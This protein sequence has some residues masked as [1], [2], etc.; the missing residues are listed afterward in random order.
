MNYLRD[1]HA[2]DPVRQRKDPWNMIHWVIEYT[3]RHRCFIIQ[4]KTQAWLART[5]RNK[6]R[7]R[8]PLPAS[9]QSMTGSAYSCMDA[10]KITSVY[11]AETYWRLHNIR[12]FLWL[13]QRLEAFTH[14]PQEIIN[15]R[16]FVH[17]IE[18]AATSQHDFNGVSCTLVSSTNSEIGCGK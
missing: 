1:K 14:L 10:V 2:T 15:E 16:S 3:T 13:P 8:M 18:C 9:S 11:H 6:R 4:S 17:M 12:L 7:P 5:S